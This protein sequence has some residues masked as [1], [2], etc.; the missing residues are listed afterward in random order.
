MTFTED[1]QGMAQC[2]LHTPCVVVGALSSLPSCSDLTKKG[3]KK[4]AV[5]RVATHTQKC[6]HCDGQQL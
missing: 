2:L 4:Q 6:M 5:L 3:E 1:I